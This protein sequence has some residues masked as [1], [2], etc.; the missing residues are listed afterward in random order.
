MAASPSIVVDFG[1]STVKAGFQGQDAPNASFSSVVGIET[2][3]DEKKSFLFG[4]DISKRRDG[5]AIESPFREGI[6]S[7]WAK[8][9]G[10]WRH[11]FKR[12]N[13]KNAENHGV[14]LCEP[15]FNQRAIREKHAERVFESY[16]SPRLFLC[17]NAALS[18]YANARGTGIVYDSGGRSTTVCAVIEGHVKS[19]SIVKD[20]MSGRKLDAILLDVLERS[21][22]VREGSLNPQYMYDQSVHA[23]ASTRVKPTNRPHVLE[24]FKTFMTLELGRE[25]REALCVCSASALTNDASAVQKK[26]FRL[27]DHTNVTIGK[28]R[29]MIPELM[30]DSEA[31]KT[32][33]NF[34]PAHTMVHM[35]IEKSD[36][37]RL[38]KDLFENVVVVGGNTSYKGFSQRL[39]HE[40]SARSPAAFRTKIIG[41]DRRRVDMAWLGG[42]IL[43]SLESFDPM[44]VTRKEFE[45]HG[46]SI[47]DRK[48]P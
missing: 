44:W 22:A 1:G 20:H 42:S 27:P 26:S 23:D 46:A 5:V 33:E 48:C 30:F 21:D 6:V 41:E 3:D 43:A 14:L 18:C 16:A 40:L 13:V 15:V 10:L 19:K 8:M 28:E 7:D 4:E 39:Y 9:D 31:I 24:S 34:F 32:S 36:E 12:L 35:A 11:T 17:K 38:K 29:H 25:I 2:M 47:V 37:Q 45:E